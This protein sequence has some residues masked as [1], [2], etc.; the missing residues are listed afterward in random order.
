MHTA[1][2]LLAERGTFDDVVEE[3][4]TAT[5]I[6]ESICEM[7]LAEILDAEVAMRDGSKGAGAPTEAARDALQGVFTAF[8]WVLKAQVTGDRAELAARYRDI[9]IAEAKEIVGPAA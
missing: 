4:A 6:S 2:T 7:V 5:F 8:L 3:M 1:A 9:L